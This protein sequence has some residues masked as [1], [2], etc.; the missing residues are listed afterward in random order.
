MSV[1]FK[2]VDLEVWKQSVISLYCI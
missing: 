1:I 2:V